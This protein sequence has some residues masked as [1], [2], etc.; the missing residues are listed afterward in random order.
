MEA[1]EQLDEQDLV[2]V[3]NLIDKLLA[4]KSG[5]TKPKKSRKKQQEPEVK[6]ATGMTVKKIVNR[7]IRTV[8]VDN[9]R[10]TPHSKHKT[11]RVEPMDIPQ[12]RPNLFL[13]SPEAKL[14]A[15]E[16]AIDKKLSGNQTPVP[17]RSV[18]EMYEIAC[19][20]CGRSCIV[21]PSVL[22]ADE[23]TGEI[24]YTCDNCIRR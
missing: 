6:P 4:K 19:K 17:R 5:T 15:N 1:L 22:L 8:G 16:K 20:I 7:R 10:Q 23:D 11:C 13:D 3:K 24:T 12:K 9:V 2:K 14:F 18:A 21:S